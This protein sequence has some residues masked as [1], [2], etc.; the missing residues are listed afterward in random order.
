MSSPCFV[1]WISLKQICVNYH[2]L[3]NNFE[4]SCLG[5]PPYFLSIFLFSSILF[6]LR[7]SFSISSF[8]SSF[9]FIQIF[10]CLINRKSFT[11]S[12]IHDLLEL[13]K[14]SLHFSDTPFFRFQFQPHFWPF[15]ALPLVFNLFL[16]VHL[17]NLSSFLILLAFQGNFL[18]LLWVSA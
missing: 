7:C 5:W 1:T 10:A 15:S 16:K 8:L 11:S 13:S 18:A 4:G 3:S 6:V 14:L 17:V 9:I 12:M 2:G